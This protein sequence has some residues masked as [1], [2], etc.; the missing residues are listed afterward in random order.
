MRALSDESA[1]PGFQ[2]S[3][4]AEGEYPLRLVDGT[5]G[6]SLGFAQESV[7]SGRMRAN[8]QVG[9]RHALR[10][11]SSPAAKA[12]IRCVSSGFVPALLMGTTSAIQ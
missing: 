2:A 1:A 12:A 11:T 8:A 3:F 10:A 9:A 7:R 6:T 5:L 4:L